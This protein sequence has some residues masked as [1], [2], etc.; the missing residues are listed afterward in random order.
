MNTYLIFSDCCSLA[1]CNLTETSCENITSALQS[2]NSP[3]RELDLSNNDLQDSGLKLLYEGLKSVKC[4]LE[5][6]R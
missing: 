2:A 3:L 1:N 5:I 6:L 4:K